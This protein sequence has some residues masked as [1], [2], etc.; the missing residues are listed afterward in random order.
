[1]RFVGDRDLTDWRTPIGRWLARLVNRLTGLRGTRLVFVVL[2]IVGLVLATVMAAVFAQVY[3]AITEGEGIAQL[4]WPILGWAVAHRTPGL[5]EA[6]TWFT[7]S[8]GPVWMPVI[9]GVAALILCLVARSWTPLLLMAAGAVGSL[10]MTIVAKRLVGRDRPPL[11]DAVPPYESSASFPSGHALNSI[12]LTAV[13][14]YVILTLV[15][16]LAARIVTVVVGGIYA[17]AMGLSRVFLGH[18]WFSDVVAAWGL[19]L[20]WVILI[21]TTHR[22]VLTQSRR[23][24]LGLEASPKE[25]LP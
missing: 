18:H 24:E 14:V 13:A 25:A 19:G 3:D 15:A 8:G 21:V 9:A 16:S 20:A 22:L 5:D 2:S 6:V 17:M 11:A 7:T 12:V 4:D 1:M 10:T 23:R